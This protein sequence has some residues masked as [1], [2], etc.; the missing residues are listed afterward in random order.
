ML[1]C[2]FLCCSKI[3]NLKQTAR[4]NQVR[5]MIDLKILYYVVSKLSPDANKEMGQIFISY[6]LTNRK[7]LFF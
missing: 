3:D 2:T 7:M 6:I 1:G 4:L 5:L